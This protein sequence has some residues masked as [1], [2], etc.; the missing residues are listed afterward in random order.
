MPRYASLYQRL[1]ANTVLA[2]PDNPLSCWLWT[3][4]TQYNGYPRL[5]I[6]REEGPRHVQAHRAMLEELL[7]AVFPFDE[8]GHLCGNP[9]CVSPLHLEVQTRAHN[10]AEQRAGV[11]APSADRSWI[12]VLFPRKPEIDWPPVGEP[13]TACPF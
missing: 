11:A 3:G 2:E 5:C 6:R 10:M 4:H 12:P 7:D 1:V 13:A 9:C 8:G